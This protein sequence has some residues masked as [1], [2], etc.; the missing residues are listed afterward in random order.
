M[1]GTQT[2]QEVRSSPA[3]ARRCPRAA[4]SPP[5]ARSHVPAPRPSTPAPDA[6]SLTRSI[7]S[8]DRDALGAFFEAWFDRIVALARLTSG[9]DES[10]CLDAAQEVMLRV[11]RAMKPL[12]DEGALAAWVVRATRSAVTDLVRSQGRRGT[13][14]RA[15]AR[16]ATLVPSAP[17]AEL[18]DWLRREFD[19]LP[20][21]DRA[22]VT[23]RVQSGATLDQAGASLG[24]SGDAA[25]GRVRRALDRMKR[26]AQEWFV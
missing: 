22:L 2:G 12:P 20:E 13:R 4:G 17:A 19:A 6:A 9:R 23:L 1:L 16:D 21:E 25:H 10:F 5:R 18:A 24:M 11:A 14:E 7:A 26:S 8:G 3:A 15:V